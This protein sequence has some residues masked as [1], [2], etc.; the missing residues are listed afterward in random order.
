MIISKNCLTCEAYTDLLVQSVRMDTK[1]I[2]VSQRCWNAPLADEMHQSMNTFWVI[3]VVVPKHV[4]IGDKSPRV[5]LVASVHAGKLD[6]ISQKK[7][8]EVVKDKVLVAIFCEELQRPTAHVSHSIARAF[9]PGDGGYAS[10][11]F[12]LR[13]YSRQ[14]LGV[15]QVRDIVKDFKCPP[16]A[17]GFGV[18]ASVDIC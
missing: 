6:R 17:G 3:D 7:D 4:I 1:A 18:N 15:R 11:Y 2:D 5:P 16:G 9:L 12:C 14:E 10:Q 13:A 8:G